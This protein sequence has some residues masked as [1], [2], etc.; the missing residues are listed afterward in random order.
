[1]KAI[2]E[3]QKVNI[4]SGDDYRILKWLQAGKYYLS[5]QGSKGHYCQPRETLPLDIYI[6]MELA[7]INKK[8][9]YVNAKRSSVLKSFSRYSELV[10]T[11]DGNKV[12]VYAYVPVDL[13]NDIY[14]FL[15]K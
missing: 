4:S 6:S 3:L 8:E 5:I 14:L 12:V 7:I 1:M 11:M 2:Q 9:K 13:I 15:T 10:R